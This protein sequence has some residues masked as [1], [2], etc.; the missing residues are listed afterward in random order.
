M[1]EVSSCNEIRYI[2][3]PDLKFGKSED[4]A[5]YFDATQF[6]LTQ[7]DIRKHNIRDF[8]IGFHFWKVAVCETYSIKPEDIIIHS[9]NGHI[10]IEESLALLFIAYVEPSFGVYML[11]RISEM[12][13]RGIV[14]SDSTLLTMARERLTKD[15]LYQIIT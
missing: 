3:F 1:K 7:G 15:D 9:S 11:E 8:E 6:I 14:V 5:Y 13:V 4:G 2:E 10:L 12:L